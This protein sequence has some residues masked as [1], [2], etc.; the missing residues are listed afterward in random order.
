MSGGQSELEATENLNL[1][2]KYNNTNFINFVHLGSI[3]KARGI[4]EI[5]DFAKVLGPHL[6]FKI[7]T[8]FNERSLLYKQF[9]GEPWVDIDPPDLNKEI[10]LNK[11]LEIYDFDTYRPFVI[12]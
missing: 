12:P 4:Y 11:S 7:N 10:Y 5:I 3:T 6:N 1:I 9:E 2:N 8:N